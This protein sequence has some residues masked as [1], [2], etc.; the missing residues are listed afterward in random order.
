M[1]FGL[2]FLGFQKNLFLSVLLLKKKELVFSKSKK[3]QLWQGR[4]HLYF[5]RKM[6][7]IDFNRDVSTENL[8][9]N[10]RVKHIKS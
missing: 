10:S 7:P 1:N 9:E 6:V 2:V 5:F 4:K 3:L 8:S